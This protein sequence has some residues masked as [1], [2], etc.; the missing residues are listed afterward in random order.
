M[1][2]NR[3]ALQAAALD[4]PEGEFSRELRVAAELRGARPKPKPP[5]PLPDVLPEPGNDVL[6]IGDS[7]AG[8]NQSLRRFRWL[9]KFC[10]DQQPAAI[11][12]IGDWWSMESLSAFERP[13]SLRFEGRRYWEDIDAGVAAQEVFRDA[14]DKAKQYKPRLIRTLGN[15]E[16]RISRTGE[17]DARFLELF[18][19]DDLRSAH[20][21]WEQVPHLRPVELHGVTFAHYFTSPGTSKAIAGNGANPPRLVFQKHKVSGVWGHS[22][23]FSYWKEPG[24]GRHYQIVNAGCFFE[25]DEAWAGEDN[26]AWDRGLCMLRNVRDGRFD[27]EWWS[28]ERVRREYGP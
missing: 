13:G 12:D 6:V 21:G 19:L 27:V 15:H 9:G 23:R 7:H 5:P 2:T 14:L 8:P 20:Y 25:H 28:M 22:H 4:A 17:A 11:V 3:A 16:H 18:T 1:S 26:R 10:A 24:L